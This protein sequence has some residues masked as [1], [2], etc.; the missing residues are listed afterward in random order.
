MV[1]QTETGLWNRKSM[2][3]KI[4]LGKIQLK[5]KIIFKSHIV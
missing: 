4:G 2:K 3:K 1:S 5:N